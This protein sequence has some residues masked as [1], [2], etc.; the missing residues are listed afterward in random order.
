MGAV[1]MG[2]IIYN[3]EH[4]DF[5]KGH[6]KFT[7]RNI[8][9]DE[10]ISIN[11]YDNIVT[12]PLKNMVAARL[13]GGSGDTDI[14]YCAVGTGSGTLIAT[15]TTLW[16]ENDRVILTTASATTNVISLIAF[17]GASDANATLAEMGY[18][19]QG[20]TAT[21]DSGE[22]CN[23][24]EISETKTSNETITIESTFTIG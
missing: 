12:N 24:T 11:E 20:A 19:G 13:A 15:N 21:T 14:T 3:N 6:H 4:L 23:H 5:I 1:H 8:E 22:M 9:T 17:F 10:I 18:F 2:I 16:T 7:M